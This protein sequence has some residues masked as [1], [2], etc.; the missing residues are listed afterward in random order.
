[1]SINY[2]IINPNQ[3]RTV[4]FLHGFLESLTMWRN[5]PLEEMPFRSVLIDLPGH[6]KSSLIQLQKDENKL[7]KIAL[8]I[9]H[10]IENLGIHDYDIIGHSLGGY[11]A[12]EM[13][14]LK[15]DTLQKI[16]LMHSNF[17]DDDEQKKLDRNRVIQVVK[18]NK[19]FF[20]KEAIP[21]LFLE[22]IRN[23]DFVEELIDEALL[24][25][26]KSIIFYSE[27]MRDRFSNENHFSD[28]N[29]NFFIVQGEKDKIVPKEKMNIFHITN[30]H[31]ISNA[32]H[33]G[34]FENQKDIEKFLSFF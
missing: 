29:E 8:E 5:L 34:H 33:M 28:N 10:F 30:Y 17:W 25:E 15:N 12:I 26:D 13:H 14:K 32:G 18:T 4:V 27:A 9:K 3:K 24:I 23:T 21:N 20:I 1:M 2:K 31:E 11:V 7:E 6:G 16:V 19:S 22:D